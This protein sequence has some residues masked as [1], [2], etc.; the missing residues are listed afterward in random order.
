MLG[1]IGGA[2]AVVEQHVFRSCDIH[3]TWIRPLAPIFRSEMLCRVSG[4]LGSTALC[5]YR[6]V[7][8]SLLS[9]HYNFPCRFLMACH[10]PPSKPPSALALV[11]EMPP[12]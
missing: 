8:V 9:M 3:C 11:G 10:P 2:A 12:N 6:C 5:P 1:R 4:A 7:T